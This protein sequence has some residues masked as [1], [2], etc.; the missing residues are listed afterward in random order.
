M[1]AC[2]RLL[3][4]VLAIIAVGCES[5]SPA[6]NAFEASNEGRGVGSNAG[7]KSNA[8]AGSNPGAKSNVGAPSNRSAAAGSATSGLSNAPRDAR[9]LIAKFECARCHDI[10]NIEPA[11]EEKHCVRCHQAIHAGTFAAKKIHLERWKKRITSIR[12]VPSLASADRLKRSWVQAFLLAPHDVRPGLIA[13]MPRLAMAPEEAATLAAYLVPDTIATRVSVDGT[14][15]RDREDDPRRTARDGFA[16]DGTADLA[17]GEQ[18]FRSLACA[19]C[20]RFTGSTVD[21][22]ALHAKGRTLGSAVDDSALHAKGRAQGS[23]V[24]DSALHAKGRAQGSTV[25]DSALRARG[26]TVDDAAHGTLEAAWALAPDLRFARQ[27]M[28]VDSM[29]A[30][31]ANPRGAMPALGVRADSARALAVFIATAPLA[32]EKARVVPARLPVLSRAVTYDEV[33]KRVFRNVCWHC[34]A[35]PDFARGD[36]GPGNSGGFGFAPRGLD[37]SSYEGVA[38]GA[39]DERGERRSVFAKLADG[40][41]RIVAHLMARYAEEAGGGGD[42]RGMPLGLPPLPLEEIQLVES[43]IVQG[44]PR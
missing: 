32:D 38:S 24:D 41:P 33:E 12:W 21:D 36:G 43:W 14:A 25:D 11:R 31:I 30:W 44:R 5:R 26:N 2:V 3:V 37:L 27:R 42:V 34:H 23:T 7:A 1:I 13:E 35:V 18:L 4:A 10:P 20:H 28:T 9:D 22:S 16:G 15:R 8:G 39:L 6:S 29:A 19:R 17:R 40:T